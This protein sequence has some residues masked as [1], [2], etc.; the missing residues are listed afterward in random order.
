VNWQPTSD[1]PGFGIHRRRTSDTS[2]FHSGINAGTSD[3]GHGSSDHGHSS[4]YGAADLPPL[5]THDFTAGLAPVGGYADLARGPSAQ[6]QMQETYLTRGP[7][8]NGHGYG[9]GY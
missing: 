4:A 6:P 5:P 3:M 7:S 8:T 2:S 9:A 1:D